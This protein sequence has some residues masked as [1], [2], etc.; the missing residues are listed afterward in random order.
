VPPYEAFVH[1]PYWKSGVARD[2]G[3]G[4][5]FDDLRDFYLE[6]V[7]GV[8]P[9]SLRRG[10]H[11]RYLELSRAVTGEVMA[12][13]FGE[14]RRAGSP[15]GGGMVLWLR[16]LVAGAG[17]GVVDHRGRPKT[18]WH[19]LR[20]ILAP[21]TVWLVDEWTGG[22]VAHIANDGPTALSARLRIALYTDL[23]LPVG[24]AETKIELPPHGAAERD[25]EAVL[26]RF[27]DAAWAY[28]FG[29]P[30]QDAIVA[31]L[32]RDGTDGPE[33][34]AQAFHFP[35]GRPLSLEPEHRLGLAATA[36]SEADGSV[37]LTLSTRRLAYGVRIHVAGFDLSDDAF[38]V[39]P[40]ASREIWLRPAQAGQLFSGGDLTALNLLG[41]VPI[42]RTTPS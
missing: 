39:E 12:H 19:H 8:D 17:W 21:T 28:R 5:D 36:T 9:A 29:P 14:W 23:E 30:A 22:V 33:L 3:S 15:S 40:G 25:V 32:E 34:V 20:R 7:F 42:R 37:R 6:L 18:A 38:S 16:D 10:N 4:W 1:N 24:Q 27:V 31:S 11:D 13:V 2:A 26:G 41:R 35:A